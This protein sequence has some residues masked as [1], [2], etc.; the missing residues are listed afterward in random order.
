MLPSKAVP[1]LLHGSEIYVK[2]KNIGKFKQ[3]KFLLSSIKECT[4]FDK[5][6]RN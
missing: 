1:T 3:E 6:E 5:Y 4:R 2:Y